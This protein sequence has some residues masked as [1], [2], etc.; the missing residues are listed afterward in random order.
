MIRIQLNE[1]AMNTMDFGRIPGGK[2]SFSPH[3]DAMTKV[4][5]REEFDEFIKAN[6]LILY[7]QTLKAYEDG[8]VYG[9]F[10]VQ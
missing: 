10:S 6:N 8:A 2:S 9:E 5:T 7:H 4:I 3:G 1:N